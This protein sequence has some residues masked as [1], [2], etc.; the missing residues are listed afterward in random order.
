MEIDMDRKSAL[1]LDAGN[2][3][4]ADKLYTQSVH[5][6]YY[7]VLQMMMYRLTQCKD[8]AI[9]YEKQKEKIRLFNSSSHDWLFSTIRDKLKKK[10]RVV[11]I[12]DFKD[13]RNDRVGADYN[14]RAFSMDESVECRLKAERLLGKL[15]ELN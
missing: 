12:E 8:N 11:F 2:K 10:S 3:L 5:C 14:L 7:S 1:S 13:L 6:F 9:S 15:R 4:V